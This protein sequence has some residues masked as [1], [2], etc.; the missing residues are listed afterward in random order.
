M[1]R[2]VIGVYTR[3]YNC[4]DKSCGP[5]FNNWEIMHT[6][7]GR[8]DGAGWSVLRT[9]GL[10]LKYIPKVRRTNAETATRAGIHK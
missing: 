4:K 8:C 7:E 10:A 9:I 5:W 1:L 2:H 6:P 3:D